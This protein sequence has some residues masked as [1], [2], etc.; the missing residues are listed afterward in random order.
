MLLLP[1]KTEDYKFA[2]EGVLPP[3]FLSFRE[4][5]LRFSNIHKDVSIG[6]HINERLK[7][8]SLE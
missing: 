2:T 1:V 7:D 8:I 3:F 4:Q 5:I 6:L